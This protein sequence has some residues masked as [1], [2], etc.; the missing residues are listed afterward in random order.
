VSA[1]VLKM[2]TAGKEINVEMEHGGKVQAELF[3]KVLIAVGRKPSSEDLGL[4]NTRVQL[5][6]KGFIRVD[7]RQQ[8]ADPRIYAIGDVVGGMLLAHKASKEARVAVEV[9]AGEAS[10]FKDIVMPAVVFT[11]P[12][13]AWAGL[14]EADARQKG[15]AVQVARFPWAA[16]GRAVSFDR[17]DG[18]TKLLIDPDT[19]RVLGAGIVG[20]GAGELIGEAVLAIEM[21]ATA[22]DLAESVHPH[23]TLAETVAECA[24]AFY[25]T[26]THTYTRKR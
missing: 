4:E 6:E 11:D 17:P 26:A 5:D 16:S 7:E 15:V 14:T 1:K 25:G 21:G 22:R 2:A 12:E 19:E 3:D 10:A 18:L 8:T 20:A 9:I 24:E 13:I 23:P